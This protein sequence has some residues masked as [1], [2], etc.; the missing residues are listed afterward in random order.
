MQTNQM[1]SL[2]DELM[3]EK[4]KLVHMS[5]EVRQEREIYQTIQRKLHD[6]RQAQR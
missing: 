2:R 3:E 5:E 6:A 1:S 4:E